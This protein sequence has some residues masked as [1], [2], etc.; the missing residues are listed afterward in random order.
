MH[1]ADT[2]RTTPYDPPHAALGPPPLPADVTRRARIAL[3]LAAAPIVVVPLVIMLAQVVK[4]D[5]ILLAAMGLS[6]LVGFAGLILGARTTWRLTR[7]DRAERPQGLVAASSAIAL[8]MV[9]G[10]LGALTALLTLA[11]FTRG[12]QLRKRGRPIFAPLAEDSPWVTGQRCD[13]EAA[14]DAAIE[15]WRANGLT[16]HASVAAFAQLSV[17]LVALGAP[18]RLIEAAHQDALDEMRHT[19]LCF[20]LA[21]DLGG[22][23]IGPGAFPRL[24]L[25]PRARWPRA[26]SLAGLA[27]ES[28]VDG[29]LN[30]GVSAR[31]VAELARRVEDPRVKHVLAQIARDEA[32][33]A[34]H[35]FDVVRWC[36]KEGGLPV[37]AALRA[38]TAAL[39]ER[40]GV[41][42]EHG[43]PQEESWGIPSQERVDRA[44]RLVRHRLLKRTARLLGAP[45]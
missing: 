18:P 7:I 17:D 45:S 5:S 29:A 30:E 3:L 34:A 19:E 21:R 8:G 39:P 9:T 38:A 35:G 11:A 13:G 14:P 27:V 36:V 26:V 12:R 2:H 15:A 31:V 23:E 24:T 41:K 42:L 33:H 1:V 10:P 20:S 16:E 6:V 44:Y 4:S 25:R 43:G 22:D 32:R 40:P 28:L 37:V